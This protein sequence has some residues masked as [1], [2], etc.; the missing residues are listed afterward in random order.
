[1]TLSELLKYHTIVRA[2][3]MDQLDGKNLFDQLPTLYQYA[4]DIIA[5]RKWEKDYRL[6]GLPYVIT[7]REDPDNK[8][9]LRRNVLTLWKEK[10]K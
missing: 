4:E 7:E 5:L 9:P 1:M 3:R 10:K 8:N 2:F 6:R